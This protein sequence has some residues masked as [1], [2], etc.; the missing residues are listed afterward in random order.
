MQ[1]VETKVSHRKTPP[2]A[3]VEFL[4]SNGENIEVELRG[5]EFA[6]MSDPDI[7]ARAKA[8]MSGASTSG[9][10]TLQ[11]EAGLDQTLNMP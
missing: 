9:G 7:I 1:I 4:G 5:E 6:E 10:D 8:T 2:G 3:C 11:D